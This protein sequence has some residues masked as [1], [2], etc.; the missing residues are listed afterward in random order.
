MKYQFGDIV[1]LRFPFTNGLG[2]KQRPAVVLIDTQDGDVLVARVTSRLRTGLYEIPIQNWQAAGLLKP[3][4]VRI[5][6]VA[7]LD[8][9]LV[10]RNMGAL[11][12]ADLRPLRQA[13]QHVWTNL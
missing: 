6:K 9:S 8:I 3:S 12:P 7:S 1:L 13:I 10:L 2:Y 5:H 4:Q 11:S